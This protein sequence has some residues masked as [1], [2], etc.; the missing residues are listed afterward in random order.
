MEILLIVALF[1]PVVY[2][3]ERTHRHTRDLPRAPFGFDAESEASSRYRRQLAELRALSGAT[4]PPWRRCSATH[5]GAPATGRAPR[6]RL[7]RLRGCSAPYR[8][9][10]RRTGRL[11]GHCHHAEALLTRELRSGARA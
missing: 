7:R 9:Q 6:C 8:R 5:F 2:L 10:L 11:V 1:A 3:M 4:S